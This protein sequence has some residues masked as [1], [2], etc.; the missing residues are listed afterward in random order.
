MPGL[1]DEAEALAKAL[2]FGICDVDEVIAWSDAQILREES[3]LVVLY[4]VSLAC[5]RY[6]QDVADMLRQSAGTPDKAN[7][8]RLL[9]TLLDGE[10]KRDAGRA[11]LIASTLYHM[12]LA[13]E[14]DALGQA[15]FNASTTWSVAIGV[16]KPKA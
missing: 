5:N 9:V 8:G 12:A 10:L 7:V 15:T 1:R 2:E 11:S 13:E 16:G 3:P 6:P 4:D 14:A